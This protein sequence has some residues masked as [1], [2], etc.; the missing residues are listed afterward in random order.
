MKYIRFMLI[1][2]MT[3]SVYS[4][5]EKNQKN[6]KNVFNYLKL[7]NTNKIKYLGKEVSDK[8]EIAKILDSLKEVPEEGVMMVSF[9]KNIKYE[10]MAFYQDDKKL[11]SLT[12]VNGRLDDPVDSYKFYT[13]GQIKKFT[14]LIKSNF[15]KK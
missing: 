10:K 12:F 2:L 9:G 8:K 11:G 6:E 1:G 7:T 5:A 15:S 3:L 4:F 14:E 13:N